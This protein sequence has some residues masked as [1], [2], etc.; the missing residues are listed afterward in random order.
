VL[1]GGGITGVAWEIGVLAGLAG[2]GIQLGLADLLVGTSAG[3]VVGAQLACGADLAQLYQEQL[4]PVPA[5]SLPAAP[6]SGG[7][8]GGG[9]GAADKMKLRDMAVFGW[10]M[11]RYPDPVRA[12]ARIGRMALAARTVPEADRRAVIAA[13]LPSAQWP[14]RR[15]LITAIDAVTGEFAVLDADSGVSL[16]DA[17]GASC[18]VPG[19]W[20]PVTM[21]GRRWIDGGVRSPANADLAA[22]CERIVVLA[23]LPRG[24]RA[25]T[26][27]THQAEALARAGRAVTV[28]SPDPDAVAAIGR[29]VLDPARRAPAARAGYAQ[30]GPALD[31]VGTVWDG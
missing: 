16:V 11:L 24:M 7:H 14:A 20:P 26:A 3:A 28:V 9:H 23:P 2:R 31:R 22:E 29:N 18:A 21:A 30:A 27:A 8:G 15:L 5:A 17:V 19:V 25:A 6:G 4:E 10:A 1:G 13:R 12:Q